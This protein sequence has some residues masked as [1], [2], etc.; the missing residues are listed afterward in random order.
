MRFGN[1]LNNSSAEHPEITEETGGEEDGGGD[2]S[3]DERNC[4][5]RG[6]VGF[7]LKDKRIQT[8]LMV[9]QGRGVLQCVAEC[10][11]VLQCV[12]VCC[13]ER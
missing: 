11:R 12:A 1:W 10:C 5:S 13:R 7:E 9:L 6:R 2:W 3:G 8:K 4:G